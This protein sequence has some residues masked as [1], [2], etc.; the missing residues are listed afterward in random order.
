M[1]SPLHVDRDLAAV[2]PVGMKQR[3]VPIRPDVGRRAR[4]VV[5][6][7]DDLFVGRDG[8]RNPRAMDVVLPEQVIG[9]DAAR[10]MDDGD[11]SLQAGT[12]RRA[13]RITEVQVRVPGCA[14]LSP[15]SSA[16]RNDGGPRRDV[17]ARTARRE[18]EQGEP[19]HERGT[20]RDKMIP[21]DSLRELEG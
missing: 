8:E 3:A 20:P 21:C 17:R 9:D 10:R 1:F 6:D 13:G 11:D 15:A 14:P 18:H 7:P 12:I 19:G 5:A 4:R 2:A 16:A